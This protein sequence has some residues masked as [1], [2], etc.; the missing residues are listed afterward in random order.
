MN[1]TDINDIFDLCA[2]IRNICDDVDFD[3]QDLYDVKKD[4]EAIRA[5][6]GTIET[7]LWTMTKGLPSDD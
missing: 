5:K 7:I 6:V 4:A 2:A 1:Q 3:A